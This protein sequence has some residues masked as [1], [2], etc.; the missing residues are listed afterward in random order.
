MT[1]Q[2]RGKKDKRTVLGYTCHFVVKNSH[3]FAEDFHEKD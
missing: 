2:D 1:L 3:R